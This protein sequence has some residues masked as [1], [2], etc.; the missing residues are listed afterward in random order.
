[1]NDLAFKK[2]KILFNKSLFFHQSKVLQVQAKYFMK[3]VIFQD[4]D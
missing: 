1:M 2:L 3:L 4:V